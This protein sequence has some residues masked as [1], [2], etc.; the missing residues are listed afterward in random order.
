MVNGILK[1][2]DHVYLTDPTLCSDILSYKPCL[3][4]HLQISAKLRVNKPEKEQP[5]RIDWRHYSS[6]SSLHM[7]ENAEWCMDINSVQE[8]GTTWKLKL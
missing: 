5:L 3:G 1:E 8:F 2:L 7:R 6:E 4:D